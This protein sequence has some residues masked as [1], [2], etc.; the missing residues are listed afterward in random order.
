MRKPG[1]IDLKCNAG[2]MWMNRVV[3][4]VRH[5]YYAVTNDCGDFK[6]TNVPPGGVSN[7]RLARKLE[8][9]PRGTDSRRGQSENDQA[10][11]LR[12]TGH[13]SKE[14]GSKSRCQS[15][16]EFSALR[17]VILP[18]PSGSLFGGAGRDRTANKGPR[19]TLTVARE[20]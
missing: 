2:H 12:R 13:D 8:G 17:A 16:R 20:R 4:V 6:L 11:L 18:C 5:P 19:P 9:R 14:S 1:V 15:Q 3:L 7:R 10:D